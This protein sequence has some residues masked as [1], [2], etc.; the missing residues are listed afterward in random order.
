MTSVYKGEEYE[1]LEVE[2]KQVPSK[3]NRNEWSYKA[4]CPWDKK[5]I[6]YS[7][8]GYKISSCEHNA[9][10]MDGKLLLKRRLDKK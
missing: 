6:W 7:F 5:W 2:M 10:F 4:R 3:A 1:I 8:D 9:G